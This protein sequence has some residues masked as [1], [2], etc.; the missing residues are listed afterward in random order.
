[1][2]PNYFKYPE[3]NENFS[4]KRTQIKKTAIIL[5]NYNDNKE[6]VDKIYNEYKSEKFDI[7]IVE[8]KDKP[9]NEY[10]SSIIH[11]IVS[12][13]TYGEYKSYHD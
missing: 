1:M 12:S 2:K 6:Q 4:Y 13:G 7:F 3:K 11:N 9:I 5:Y 8:L 10:R